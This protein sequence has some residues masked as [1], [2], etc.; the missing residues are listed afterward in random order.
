MHTAYALP[1]AS[2]TKFRDIPVDLLRGIAI[3]LM[4]A[5]NTVP[6][7]LAPPAPFPVR[8]L[9]SLAAPLFIL[10]SGM[11]VALSRTR[12]QYDLRYFL[13]RGGLVILIASGL[14]A[15]VWGIFPFIDMD[16][17]FLIGISLPLAYLFLALDRRVRWGIILTLFCA[18][19]VLQL[20]FG[21]PLLPVQ[22]PVAGSAGGIAGLTLPMVAGHWF[23]SGW[24]PVFPW[25]GL[26]FLGAELG[27]IRWA[28]NAIT[29]FATRRFAAVG[30]GMLAT[31]IVLWSFFPGPQ[32][33][34]Y[35]YVELFYPPVPGF[36]LMACGAILCMFVI[37]DLLPPA[38]LPDPLRAMGECSLTIYILHSVIIAWFIQ[39]L[40][41]LLPLPLFLL[42]VIVFIGGMCAFAYLLRRLRPAAAGRSLAVRFLMGG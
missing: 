37:A 14:E 16:V 35:G 17:L 28:G 11:M 34:R 25:L 1:P 12:K 6:Y 2:L 7:L 22:I 32:L 23:I 39:P 9:A 5:A 3:A 27:T 26:A 40:H 19:P 8:V 4:V 41:L 18:A 38:S 33:V 21:Y 30:L 31:G 13:I 36:C 20:V 29:S 10:L 15:V 24:F 42:C